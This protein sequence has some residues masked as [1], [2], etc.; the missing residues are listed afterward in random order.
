M[1]KSLFVIIMT[2][3]LVTGITS[4]QTGKVSS[5]SI[6]WRI[7]ATLPPLNGKQPGV[8]GASAGVHN[9]T[10][11]V[12]GGANF[13]D[14]MP[15]L[16]GMKRYR[17]DV[18]AFVRGQDGAFKPIKT[19]F[20]LRQP[21]AY[22]A[23]VSTQK[24]IICAG[25]END[26]GLSSEV[27]LMKWDDNN[28]TIAISDLPALPYPLTNASITANGEKVYVAGGELADAVSDGFLCLDLNDTA[29]GWKSLSTLPHPASHAVLALLSDN[30][31][32][33]VYLAGGRK[34]NAGSTSTLY[35]EVY[36]YNVEEKNWTIKTPLP[37]ALSAATGITVDNSILIFGGD[38]G[39][40]FH[41]TEQL[42]AEINAADHAADKQSLN[43]QKAILQSTHPG[44]T[45]EVLQFHP[46]VNEWKTIDTVP[47]T[48]PVT[49]TAFRWQHD[50]II[51]GGEIRAGVRTP[52]ILAGELVK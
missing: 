26:N 23:S 30:G 31:A 3:Q 29:A 40:T 24:G 11:L 22:A 7:A 38:R 21:L 47:F 9:N 25:G 5:V 4:C 45:R 14:S 19:I 37:Y 6:R 13:P 48:V 43:Q 33:Y 20:K 15:W 17:D 18:Y 32:N 39:E 42:I 36:A 35:K 2:F 28:D 46:L 8:A 41:R 52:D 44:F 10:M 51:P 49:T 50:I 12:A 1:M 34:R 27:F 16:G